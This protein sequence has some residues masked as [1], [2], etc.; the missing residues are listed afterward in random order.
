MHGSG[1]GEEF[2]TLFLSWQHVK[3]QTPTL[4]PESLFPCWGTHWNAASNPTGI[5]GKTPT[6]FQQ[7]WRKPWPGTPF[8]AELWVTSYCV[9][10]AEA[11]DS[12]RTDSLLWCLGTRCAHYIMSR[13]F[14]PLTLG[15][16]TPWFCTATGPLPWP[17]QVR[18]RSQR[19]EFQHAGQSLA[20]TYSHK[21]GMTMTRQQEI[22]QQV[23]SLPSEY[24]SASWLTYVP[25]PAFTDRFSSHQFTQNK[26]LLQEPFC[27]WTN[28]TLVPSRGSLCTNAC[29]NSSGPMWLSLS[30]WRGKG[31]RQEEIRKHPSLLVLLVEL[32]HYL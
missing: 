29:T 27:K 5:S 16:D 26:Q 19:S 21:E 1:S 17:K 10:R 11:V 32:S 23:P 31:E 18:G 25:G 12:W 7:L 8:P 30:Y 4:Q 22:Y 24:S 14:M 3:S 28:C 6:G 2:S 20:G 13:V 15:A 9:Q